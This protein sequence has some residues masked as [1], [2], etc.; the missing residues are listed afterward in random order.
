MLFIGVLARFFVNAAASW[1]LVVQ[2]NTIVPLFPLM[3]ERY[4]ERNDAAMTAL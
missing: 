2:K 4:I 3:Y 1:L